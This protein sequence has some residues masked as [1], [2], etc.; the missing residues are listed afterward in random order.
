LLVGAQPAGDDNGDA[1]N[2]NTAAAAAAAGGAAAAVAAA[3]GGTTQAGRQRRKVSASRNH[4]H[5][6]IKKSVTST[7]HRRRMAV[8]DLTPNIQTPE[9]E[10]LWDN[11]YFMHSRG[12]RTN[13]AAFCAEW[14]QQATMHKYA[15]SAAMKHK[16]VHQLQRYHDKM[17]KETLSQTRALAGM[18]MQA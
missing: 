8:A 16:Q 11:L 13:W 17:V 5:Q 12:S 4:F 2:P 10:A 1:A 18:P 14:N 3:A 15:G 7:Y 6:H 9:E